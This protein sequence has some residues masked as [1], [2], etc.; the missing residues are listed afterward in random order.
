MAKKATSMKYQPTPYKG[1]ARKETLIGE[2]SEKVQK[3][4]GMVF[5]NYQGMTHHQI[6]GLKK[7]LKKIESD[8]VIT[9][10]RLMLRTLDGITLS[11]EEKNHFQQPTATLFIYNDI[12]EPLKALTK[13]VK[14][15][16][17]PLI[18]FG[19]LDGKAISGTDV[20]KLAALPP[21]PVLRAQLLGQMQSPIQGLHRALSWNMQSL[22]MTLNA[23]KDK[24]PAA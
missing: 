3:S 6:E 17:L 23:I 7:A 4:K 1:R 11:D 2:F 5:T 13:T 22:V 14:E 10:N 15:L 18:K 21:M 20:T 9:K 19:I 24:K 8:Y 16:K 12:V